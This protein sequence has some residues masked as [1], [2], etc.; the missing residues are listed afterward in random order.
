MRVHRGSDIRVNF[1]RQVE[2]D[3]GSDGRREYR[4]GGSGDKSQSERE[5]P[6][7]QMRQLIGDHQH[8]WHQCELRKQREVCVFRDRGEQ[9]P[10]VHKMQ[11]GAPV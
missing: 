5:H 6:L 2:I 11:I 10:A 8:H 1:W 9:R 4:N 7:P 3:E